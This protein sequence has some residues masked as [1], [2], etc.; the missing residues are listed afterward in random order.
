MNSRITQAVPATGPN[1]I[2]TRST[3]PSQRRVVDAR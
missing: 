3:V 2:T 1:M